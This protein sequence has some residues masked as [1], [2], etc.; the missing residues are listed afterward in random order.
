MTDGAP[1][2]AWGCRTVFSGACSREPRGAG[3]TISLRSRSAYCRARFHDRL[4]RNSGPAAHLATMIPMERESGL[5]IRR[6]LQDSI[7]LLA[8]PTE[9]QIAWL[10]ELGVA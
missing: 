6:G 4:T 10:K 5:R 3:P 1:Q 2:R 9:A 8:S 7:A